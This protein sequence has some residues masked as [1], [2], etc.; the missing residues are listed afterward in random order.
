MIG[1]PSFTKLLALFQCLSLQWFFFHW[2]SSWVGV[3]VGVGEV[4]DVGLG[5]ELTLNWLK[6]TYISA[7]KSYECCRVILGVSFSKTL[8]QSVTYTT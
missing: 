6:S 2:L 5:K 4:N 8:L 7:V 3:Y 1:Y